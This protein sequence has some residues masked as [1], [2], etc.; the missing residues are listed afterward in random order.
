MI[1]AEA[2]RENVKPY[3]VNINVSARLYSDDV[4]VII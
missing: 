1:H 2:T 3:Y 4:Y